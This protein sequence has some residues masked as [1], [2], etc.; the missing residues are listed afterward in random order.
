MQTAFHLDLPRKRGQGDKDGNEIY[1][2]PA[3]ENRAVAGDSNEMP[4]K[5]FKRPFGKKSEASRGCL[6]PGIA[7]LSCNSA[8]PEVLGGFMVRVEIPVLQ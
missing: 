1:L 3:S 4:E 5:A 2:S 6:V 7:L 8:C